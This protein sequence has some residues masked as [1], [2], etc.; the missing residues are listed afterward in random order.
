[1]RDDD[2]LLR[3][4]LLGEL[5]GEDEALL[6][7]RLLRDDRLFERAEAVEA[8]LLEEHAHGGLSAAQRDRIRRH[9]SSS[10]ASRS[11]LAVV[12]GLGTVAEE[13][14]PGHRVLTG[15]WGRM[16]LSR[17]RVRAL[18]AAAMLAIAVLSVWLAGKIVLP[19]QEQEQVLAETPAPPIPPVRPSVP[20][21]ETPAGP[22]PERVDQV[23]P[24]PEPEPPA[25]PA[26][27]PYVFE[28]ALTAL[29]GPDDVPEELSIPA[30]T[31]QVDIRLPLSREDEAH[32]SYLVV[33]RDAAGQELI[34]RTDLHPVRTGEKAALVLPVEAK[35]LRAGRYSVDV[36]GAGD[37][38]LGFPEFQVVEP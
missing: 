6:E 19:P 14:K 29:R 24:A 31:E 13:E 9:L 2:E 23:E 1:M 10:P 26:P 17:A 4:Y 18:A 12:R 36:Y 16:D 7:A 27:I 8:D 3:Q 22:G 32:P 20:P 38:A 30:G 35:L 33:L 37:N 11:R 25:P 28:L 34:R 21:A 5:A 15:P